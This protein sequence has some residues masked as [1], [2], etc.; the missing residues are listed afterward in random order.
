M[1]ATV[2]AAAPE[3]SPV[4]FRV[5][6]PAVARV[7]T[8]LGVAVVGTGAVTEPGPVAGPGPGATAV[9]GA[10]ATLRLLAVAR[11]LVLPLLGLAILLPPHPFPPPLVRAR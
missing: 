8:L 10:G 9:A 2:T 4:L 3:L 5:I 7:S 1:R 6:V 11:L